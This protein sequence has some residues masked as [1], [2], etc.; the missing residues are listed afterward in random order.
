MGIMGIMGIIILVGYY[1]Y[2]YIDIPVINTSII[3][4]YSKEESGIWLCGVWW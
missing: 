1:R 4:V 3:P 2:I